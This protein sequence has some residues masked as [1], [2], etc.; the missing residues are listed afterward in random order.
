MLE[1]ASG[2]NLKSHHQ[3]TVKANTQRDVTGIVLIDG[4]VEIRDLV[5]KYANTYLN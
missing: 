1:I 3:L 5:I 2:T 4:A